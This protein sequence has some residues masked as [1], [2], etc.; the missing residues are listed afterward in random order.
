M[1]SID[2]NDFFSHFLWMVPNTYLQI[3]AVQIHAYSKV[4]ATTL[5]VNRYVR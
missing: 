5:N 2:R 1:K 4:L 3:S